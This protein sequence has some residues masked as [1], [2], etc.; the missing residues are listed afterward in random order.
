MFEK[1]RTE[2]ASD[3]YTA[4]LV[5]AQSTRAW[6]FMGGGFPGEVPAD[7]LKAASV[8]DYYPAFE[9]VLAWDGKTAGLVYDGN[10]HNKTH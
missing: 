9:N 5:N 6:E 1:L 10:C 7:V 2:F 4:D 8:D 3:A